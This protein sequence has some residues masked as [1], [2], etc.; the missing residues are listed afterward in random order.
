MNWIYLF[1]AG[2]LEVGWAV[3]LKYTEGWSRLVPSA[4]TIVGMVASFYFLSLALKTLPIGT[5]YA[6]WTGIGTVGAAL[7]G[8]LLFDEP[9]EIGRILCILLIVAG[10]AGLKLTSAQ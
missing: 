8:M 3:G 10:I 6:V 4:L 5:A 2:I 1:I 7:L 9:R